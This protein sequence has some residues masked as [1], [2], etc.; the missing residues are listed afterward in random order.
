MNI[1]P[2]Q[3]H[4]VHAKEREAE[5][6]YQTNGLIETVCVSKAVTLYTHRTQQ[7]QG[8]RRLQKVEDSQVCTSQ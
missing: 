2:G 4:V 6:D 7:M 3:V 1:S 8:R 5:K